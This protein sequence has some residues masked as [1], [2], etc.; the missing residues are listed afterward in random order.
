M[1]SR[2]DGHAQVAILETI[3]EGGG[4]GQVRGAPDTDEPIVG[5]AGEILSI[6]GS[7]ESAEFTHRDSG[8]AYPK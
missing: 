7:A 3:I 5:A 1:V 8:N 2:I 4:Q 6:M